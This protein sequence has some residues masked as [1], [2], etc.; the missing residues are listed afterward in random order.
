[1]WL[2]VRGI[3]GH[4]VM[5]WISERS[6]RQQ[7]IEAIRH[8]AHVPD[9]VAVTASGQYAI[10]VELSDKGPGRTL[11]TALRLTQ[12]Y[13]YVIYMVPAETQTARTVRGAVEQAAQR[14]SSTTGEGQIHIMEIP[15]RE[16][17]W[18]SQG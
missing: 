9:G 8:G 11:E 17:M 10:E 6:W 7:H 2:D 4:P 16:E 1:M 13:P 15:S 5:S 3:A 14:M 12:A 18:R